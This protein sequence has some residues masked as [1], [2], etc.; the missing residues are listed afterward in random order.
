VIRDFSTS[1]R[2]GTPGDKAIDIVVQGLE[3]CGRSMSR[4]N[5]LWGPPEEY[6]T[7]AVLI[8]L[9]E[10]DWMHIG[11]LVFDVGRRLPGVALP[12]FTQALGDL[13][14]VLIDHDV[15]PGEL[16]A[17]FQPWPGTRQERSPVR[18][19]PGLTSIHT[20]PPSPRRRPA[21]RRCRTEVN[22]AAGFPTVLLHV[23]GR[24][25]ADA[26]AESARRADL[27]GWAARTADL[28]AALVEA[29]AAVAGAAAPW[30]AGR[31]VPADGHTPRPRPPSIDPLVT[32]T[33]SA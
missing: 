20:P 31:R 14:G 21:P 29:T 1:G 7:V 24:Q 23:L 4:R 17:E 16:K 13:A 3:G 12:E 10:D 32:P 27:A 33:R 18:R 19:P 22:P 30:T 2:R 5:A 9:A 11:H 8:G 6:E 28:G 15:V 26:A 25:A